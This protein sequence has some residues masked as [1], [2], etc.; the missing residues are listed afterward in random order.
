MSF[1]I[2]I[3]QLFTFRATDIDDLIMNTLG[4]AVGYVIAKIFFGKKYKSEKENNDIKKL[5]IMIL[6]GIGVVV[7]VHSR[8]VEY[9]WPLL[10]EL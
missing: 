6:L 9:L 4:A 7:F 5:V 2:E 8:I 10:E 3:L 1:L